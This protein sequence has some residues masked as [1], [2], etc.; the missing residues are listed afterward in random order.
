MSC[1][2]RVIE[3]LLILVHQAALNP[4][5]GVMVGRGTVL[6]TIS[7]S[8]VI[9]KQYLAVNRERQ[10][11]LVD[12]IRGGRECWLVAM[13][14]KNRVETFLRKNVWEVELSSLPWWKS[15]L[16]RVLRVFYVVIRDLLEGQ[17]TLRAMSLVYT[18]LLAMVPLL[19]VSFSVLKGFG[20]HNQIEPLLL[21]FLRPM[22]ERGV[23]VTSRI[24]GFVDSVK[25]GVLGSVGFALLIYTVI[26]LI[27]KIEQAC[28][29]T[30]QVN[31]SRPLSQKFSDYLSVILI[32]PLLVFSAL[33]ITAS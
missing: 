28:N 7:V 30:W 19:A 11:G 23:E 1:R 24:I 27:Q 14:K 12:V 13:T 18:T 3:I 6:L 22:G 20:V 16:T 5:Q 32:G 26:S 2:R 15:W 31:R 9:I 21:N 33:G 29:D 8:V 10:Y 25:A 4:E 17:L